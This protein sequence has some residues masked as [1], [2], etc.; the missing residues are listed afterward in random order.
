M[1]QNTQNYERKRF[2]PSLFILQ[3]FLSQ[4][5]YPSVGRCKKQKKQSTTKHQKRRIIMYYSRKRRPDTLQ[6]S[7]LPIAH[8]FGIYRINRKTFQF[9]FLPNTQYPCLGHRQ[10]AAPPDCTNFTEIVFINSR[11]NNFRT[12]RDCTD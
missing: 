7:H 5:K 1:Y 9:Y 12:S 3:P 10:L 2:T 8:H 6:I 11:R 4:P